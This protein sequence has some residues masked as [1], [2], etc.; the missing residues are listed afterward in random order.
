MCRRSWG[1]Q[2]NCQRR[3]KP[4]TRYKPMKIYQAQGLLKED[5]KSW[6]HMPG[7]KWST[8]LCL[9][10][11][12]AEPPAK[13][14]L[15]LWFLGA[16]EGSSWAVGER[17][18]PAPRLSPP[19][20]CLPAIPRCPAAQTGQHRWLPVCCFWPQHCP[21]AHR[22]LQLS[23]RRGRKNGLDWSI[24]WGQGLGTETRFQLRPSPFMT[25]SSRLFVC[26]PCVAKPLWR[27]HSVYAEGYYSMSTK[28]QLIDM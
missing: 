27:W 26:N 14:C 20:C 10:V 19:R 4:S 22:L 8:V 2:G 15:G 28:E 25:L 11:T 9:N 23:H 6:L 5:K 21:H 1:M 18:H 3:P 17:V 12:G 13:G 7:F 24:L 16:A